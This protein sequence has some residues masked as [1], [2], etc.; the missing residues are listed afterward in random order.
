M[1]LLGSFLTLSLQ[2][3][4]TLQTVSSLRS[5]PPRKVLCRSMY[6]RLTSHLES[7]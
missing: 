4:Y 5:K 6:S 3:Q 2:E 7:F 1:I